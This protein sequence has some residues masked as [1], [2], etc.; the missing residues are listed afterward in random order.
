[1]KFNNKTRAFGSIRKTKRWGTCGVILGLAALSLAMS[2]GVSA[3]E[4]A[5]PV[6]TAEVANTASNLKDSQPAPTTDNQAVISQANQAQGSVSVTVDNTNVTEA[7]AKAKA[8]GVNVVK[9][10]TVDKGTTASSDATHAVQS[11]IA[12]AQNEQQKQI[13]QA[14]LDYVNQKDEHK[15]EVDT[16]ISN[17]KKI[18]TGKQ[19]LED[20]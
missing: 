7:V 1:M 9:D 19:A 10:P 16:V 14:T 8:E 12:T 2:N 4:I 6:S 15:K 17:N 3:D 5:S 13:E 11:E 20:A 18:Q